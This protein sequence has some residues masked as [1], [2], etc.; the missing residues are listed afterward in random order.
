M[1]PTIQKEKEDALRPDPYLDWEFRTRSGLPG[2]AP[3]DLWCSLYVRV[4]L[5]P[6]N[7]CLANLRA[8]D[9]A[10]R[11]GRL[12]EDDAARPGPTIRMTDGERAL[13]KEVIRTKSGNEIQS[14]EH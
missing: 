8:L 3:D 12:P 9:E 13:L 6:D 10:V 7:D 5:G 1:R 14:D 4:K 11:I 2:E